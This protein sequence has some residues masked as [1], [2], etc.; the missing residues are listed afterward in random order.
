MEYL[1]YN[2]SPFLEIKTLLMLN[3]RSSRPVF[4]N[5]F[6]K[7][8]GKHLWCSP[9]NSK[10]LN[11]P[12]EN[13]FNNQQYTTHIEQLIDALD[14]LC[15]FTFCIKTDFCHFHLN[16]RNFSLHRAVLLGK[17]LVESSWVL[18]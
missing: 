5:N 17:L 10:I 13:Q 9:N 12:L 6:L 14:N 2:N 15:V 1:H 4:S 7:L 18:S 3:V 11:R 16:L 8:S